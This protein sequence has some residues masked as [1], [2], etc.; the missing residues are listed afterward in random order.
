MIYTFPEGISANWNTDSFIQDLNSSQLFIYL[1][2]K[3]ITVMLAAHDQ[4]IKYIYSTYFIINY[5][6]VNL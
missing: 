2:V 5:L 4:D 6:I 3:T 1:C